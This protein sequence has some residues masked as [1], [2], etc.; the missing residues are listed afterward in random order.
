MRFAVRCLELGRR[1]M[2]FVDNRLVMIPGIGGFYRRQFIVGVGALSELSLQVLCNYQAVSE[3]RSA[4]RLQV[5]VSLAAMVLCCN[6]QRY[7]G[8]GWHG[9]LVGL[10]LRHCFRLTHYASFDIAE[11]KFMG[12]DMCYLPASCYG[13]GFLSSECAVQQA[14]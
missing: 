9:P 6:N 11:M 10:G 5:V 4:R 12:C 2:R 1:W 14:V 7:Y 3:V 13:Q 8:K